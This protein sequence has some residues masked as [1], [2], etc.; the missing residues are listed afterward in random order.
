M[1]RQ[2]RFEL[3]PM[4]YDLHSHSTA[5]DGTLGPAALV[6]RA[7][8][9]GVDVLA[10]TD[11]DSTAGHAEARA[12]AD[13]AGI[14]FVPGVEISVTWGGTTVHI[15]G[16]HVDGDHPAL[17]RALTTI[18]ATRD[19]RAEAIA[20][21][22][23]QLGIDNALAKARELA[24]GGLVART[25]FARLLVNQG[26]ADDVGA[27]MK[28]YL[29]R[30]KAA[31][32]DAQWA[33]LEDAVAW[34]IEAGGIPVIA[35]PARYKFTASKL[36]V[37]TQSFREMGGQAMEVVSGSHGPDD[38]Q[39]MAAH[40]RRAGLYASQGSDYHGPE[41]PWVELG[42]LGTLPGDLKPVWELFP[43]GELGS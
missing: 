24:P 21:K 43:G 32:V 29:L 39:S 11:H 3:N 19:G 36:R 42:R 4:H 15:V 8:C 30:G 12:A 37:L 16:L 9:Q 1:R 6:Q 23:G 10:L 28:K 5:S 41:N 2:A 31:Y 18:R 25:H 7:A 26:L 33:D 40:C 13:E 22:V 14:R 38:V 17:Q 20:E 35:H 34:I 27:A